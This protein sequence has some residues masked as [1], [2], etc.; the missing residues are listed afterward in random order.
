MK[1][2]LM[3]LMVLSVSLFGQVYTIP[4]SHAAIQVY[5]AVLTGATAGVSSSA[6]SPKDWAGVATLFIKGDTTGAS[7]VLANQSDSCLTIGLQLKAGSMGWGRP[8]DETT[9]YARID[10][11]ARSLINTGGNVLYLNLANKVP[12]AWAWADSARFWMSIGTTDSLTLT[13]EVGGQ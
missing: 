3:V 13:L 12:D 2:V 6:F 4:Q 8:Y 7:V 10:T 11:V 5:N 1:Q 9:T